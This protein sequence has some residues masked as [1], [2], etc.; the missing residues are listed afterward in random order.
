MNMKEKQN[1]LQ[2]LQHNLLQA[3]Q[4]M[5]K[6]TNLRRT[7]RTFDLGAM[8]YLKMQPYRETTLGLCNALK[9]TSKWY[10]PFKVMQRVGNAAYKLQLPEGT[11]LH[12]VFHVNQLKCHLGKNAIPNPQLPLII[13]DS[14]I[15]I[16]P[17]AILA[18][19]Q[20]P[21]NAG[22]YQVAEPQ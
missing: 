18:Q 22:S 5:K 7:E 1:M 4:R 17:L 6:Y 10:G 12:D 3:H 8:V 9:L 21:R 16:A 19:R 2:T 14:K 15:K 11:L 13:P 20:V